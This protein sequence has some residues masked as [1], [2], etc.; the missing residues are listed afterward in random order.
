V[1]GCLAQTGLKRRT[2]LGTATLLVAVNAPDVDIVAAFLGHNLGWR[3][4]WTH[5]VLGIALWPFL[6][7]GLA[8]L[9]S[10]WRAPARPVSARA[11]LALAAIGVMTHP[12]LDYLNTYG[13]RWLMPFRDR[14]YYGDTLFIVDPWLWAFLVIGIVAARRRERRGAPHPARPARIGLG[15]AAGYVGLMALST[16]A[17]RAAVR[18]QVGE[19]ARVMVAPLPVT[20]LVKDVVVD[21]GPSYRRGRYRFGES[22][23]LELTGDI[24][25]NDDS[26]TTRTVSATPAGRAFLHWSR[27]PAFR[28]LGGGDSMVVR[29]YDLRYTDGRAPSWASVDVPVGRER[30]S[31]TNEPR[32]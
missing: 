9:W 5:G 15:L 26:E 11:L 29:A 28:R 13:M 21:A 8:L 10:R 30:T 23:G 19:R 6:I 16:V 18:R 3:R 17:A 2:G 12:V 32:R 22:P 7:A 14:W 25:K 4:G 20:P 31:G 24:P 27:L 1:G